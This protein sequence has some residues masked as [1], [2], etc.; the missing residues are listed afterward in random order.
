MS[1]VTSSHVFTYEMI[2]FPF[3]RLRKGLRQ[4]G[5]RKPAFE[6]QLSQDEFCLKPSYDLPLKNDLLFDPCLKLSVLMLD[7]LVSKNWP[8][9]L[10]IL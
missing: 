4:L 10:V 8:L 6:I 3:H 9:V 7:M 5:Q 1:P 2:L